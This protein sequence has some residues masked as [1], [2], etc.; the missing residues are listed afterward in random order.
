MQFAY[1]KKREKEYYLQFNT[2]QVFQNSTVINPNNEKQCLIQTMKKV[3]VPNFNDSVVSDLLRN[4]T[5]G[6]TVI[7]CC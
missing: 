1:V 5:K 7:F 4:F 2:N 3:L 6:Q